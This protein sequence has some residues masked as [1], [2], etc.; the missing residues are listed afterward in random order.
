M[1]YDETFSPVVRFESLR[2]LF[3][4]AVQESMELHQMD[5]SSAFL[6]GTLKEEINLKQ[7]VGFVVDGKANY[8]YKLHKSLYGLKQ[9]PRC[10]NSELDVCLGELGFVTSTSDSCIYIRKDKSICIVTV[11]VDDLIIASVSRSEISKL[12]FY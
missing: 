10:W 1:N 3:S 7:P 8:V 2:A 12:V 5:V 11:Y 4:L 9:S 6:N